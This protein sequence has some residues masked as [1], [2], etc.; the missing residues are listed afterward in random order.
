MTSLMYR[1]P[2]LYNLLLKLVHGKYLPIRYKEIARIIGKNKKVLDLGCGTCL[3]Y[4]YLDTSC[5]Y[6]GWDLNEHFIK[7]NKGINVKLK[8]AFDY[9]NYPKTD[10]I[11]ISDLLHHI[12]PRHEELIRNA[13]GRTKKLIILE[14]HVNFYTNNKIKWVYKLLDKM[15]GD[16]DGFNSFD[17][18][19]KWFKNKKEVYNFFMKFKP[20]MIKEIG[21][22]YLVVL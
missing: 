3:L 8:D 18:R 1:F 17:N 11:V 14:P 20:K 12:T 13:Q 5:S 9:N 15:F 22:D 10:V 2:R 7:N 4:K 21:L 6:E 16:D 19:S